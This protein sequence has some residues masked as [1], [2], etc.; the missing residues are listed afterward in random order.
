MIYSELKAIESNFLIVTSHKV[1]RKKLLCGNI[2]LQQ[3]TTWVSGRA[4]LPRNRVL[5]SWQSQMT[6]L[7]M[8]WATD[9]RKS[10]Q[11]VLRV[12]GKPREVTICCKKSE[13]VF[14]ESNL[15]HFCFNVIFMQS[16]QFYVFLKNYIS[17][18][19]FDVDTALKC[20]KCPENYM[21]A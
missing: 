18:N 9:C 3:C 7:G 19:S 10:S 16:K 5:E 1:C 6:W 4:I 14:E 8:G 13:K 2:I 20:G 17:T 11:L 21:T 15:K 12:C